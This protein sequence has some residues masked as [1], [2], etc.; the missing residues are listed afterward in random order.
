MK[1][2]LS[3]VIARARSARSNLQDLT[4]NSWIA[5]SA[6]RLCRTRRRVGLLAMTILSSLFLFGCVHG[7]VVHDEV[8]TCPLPMD[9][10]FLRTVEAVQTHPD[11]ELDYTDKEKGIIHL[12]NL[13]YSSFDD[14]DERTATL[15]LKRIGRRE[16]SIQL[17]PESQSILGVDEVLKLIKQALSREAGQG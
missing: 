8:L 12:R 2:L 1:S 6:S 15:V 17:A 4:C 9:L 11:W 7:R 13:K 14:S 16:T 3:F 5:S 10:T